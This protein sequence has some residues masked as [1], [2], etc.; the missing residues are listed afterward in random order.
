MAALE[1]RN[2]KRVDMILELLLMACTKFNV[3]NY[4]NKNYVECTDAKL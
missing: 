1:L 2:T 3:N 4:D